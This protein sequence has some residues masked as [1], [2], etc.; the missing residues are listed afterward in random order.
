MRCA[1]TASR[2]S[3]RRS[4]PGRA[5][6]RAAFLGAPP[7]GLRAA[8]SF[9]HVTDVAVAGAV[10][11]A[12][13]HL[14][15]APVR[16]RAERL[17]VVA[18]GGYGRGEMAPFSDVDLLFLTPYKRTA[19]TESVIESVLY[20]LWDLKLKVGHSVRSIDDC[21]RLAA[22]RHDDPHGAAR[23]ALPLRRP[24][25]RSTRSTSGSGTSSSCKTGPEFVEA[26]MA[27]RDARHERHGGSRY[28]LEP[29]VKES[30]GGLRDLQTLHWISR[31][32]YRTRTAWDLVDIGVFEQRRGAPLR[33]GREVHLGRALPPARPAG[34][35]AGAADLR[36]PGRDRRSACA[37]PDHDG[38]MAVEHFMHDYFRHAKA[39]GDLTRIF[40]AALEAQHAKP[41]PALSMLLQA[42]SFRSARAPAP[43]SPSRCRAVG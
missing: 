2:C 30:K 40:S 22:R 7:A 4:R 35:A 27:E 20:L 41:A 19:W 10:H 42:L 21:L 29:N 5:R 39:V 6:V 24:R 26:K 15:P 1:A 9:A 32:L 17:A 43:P 31:Y 37:M 23:D 16:T 18:V 28:L 34:R 38:R 3:P 13:A 8:R 25:R 14:H 12:S 11:L 36:P 33:R